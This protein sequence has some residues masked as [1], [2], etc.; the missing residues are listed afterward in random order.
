MLAMYKRNGAVQG[1]TFET[2]AAVDTGDAVHKELKRR[3]R[4]VQ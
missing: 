4:M 2:Q 1:T 3:S